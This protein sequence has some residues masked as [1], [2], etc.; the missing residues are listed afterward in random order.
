MAQVAA[1]GFLCSGRHVTDECIKCVLRPSDEGLPPLAVQ[2]FRPQQ[3][4][5]AF[6]PYSRKWV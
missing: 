1:I 2:G 5:L 3:L 6:A 4:Q